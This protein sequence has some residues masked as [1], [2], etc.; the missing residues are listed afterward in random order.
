MHVVISSEEVLKIGQTYFHLSDAQGVDHPDQSFRVVAESTEGAWLDE[1][2]SPREQQR[3][4]KNLD[5]FP[6]HFYL[7]QTD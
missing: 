1:Y 7:V 4:K 3:W 2:I 5:G 6:Y